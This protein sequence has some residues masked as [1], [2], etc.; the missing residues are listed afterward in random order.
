MDGEK[1]YQ[2]DKNVKYI[3]Q[4]GSSS[5]KKLIVVFSGYAANNSDIKHKYN[6]MNI[7]SD[8]NVHKLFILDEN[9]ETGSYYF[10]DRMDFSVD[11]SV[12]SLILFK[13]RNSIY[14][15]KI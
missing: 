10:G 6:Y 11:S 15:W 9:G 12:I 5:V 3:F 8:I 7:L 13:A 14:N 1:I 2:S 4:E